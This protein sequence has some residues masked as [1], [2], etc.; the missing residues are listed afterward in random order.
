MLKQFK[1][2]CKKIIAI[3][4]AQRWAWR[5]SD[6]SMPV[7]SVSMSPGLKVHL[8][9]GPIN[10]QGWVNV[11]ARS[12]EHVHLVS[13][14]LELREFSDG[15]ISEI[16]LCHILEH[17]SFQAAEAL[18]KR[19]KLKLCSGG[20]IRISVPNFDKLI[21]VYNFGGGDLT[22]VQSALMGGQDYDYNFHKSLYNLSSLREL[23]EC[24]GYSQISEWDTL[25]DFGVSLGDWSDQTFPTK[26]GALPISLNLKAIN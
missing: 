4:H 5:N 15:A 26:Q 20:L 11:D 2:T 21:E 10:I 24:C 14:E 7:Y 25:I 16:Y 6:K 3:C 9:S 19:L 23:L 22:K 13:D 18:L 12:F 8:G 1:N 17:F